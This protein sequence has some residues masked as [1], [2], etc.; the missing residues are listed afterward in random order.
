MSRLLRANKET[1]AVS[2]DKTGLRKE[3]IDNAILPMVK[4]FAFLVGCGRHPHPS[5]TQTRRAPLVLGHSSSTLSSESQSFMVSNQLFFVYGG[6]LY[7]NSTP[8]LAASY[9]RGHRSG[10]RAIHNSVHNKF[11]ANLRQP[12]Y[13]HPSL[14]NIAT[15]KER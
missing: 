7:V 10:P 1:M 11:L 13:K 3:E 5:G 8:Y 12:P 14:L 15:A 9:G 6:S 4:L 2:R